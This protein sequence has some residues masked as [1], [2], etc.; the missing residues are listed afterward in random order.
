MRD[1]PDAAYEANAAAQNTGSRIGQIRK[2][3]SAE[4]PV[5]IAAPRRK[6][7]SHRLIIASFYLLLISRILLQTSTF[8]QRFE[9]S[10]VYGFDSPL[11][12]PPLQ[13]AV[14]RPTGT[15]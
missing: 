3:A 9:V 10:G 5:A 12:M 1:A 14:Q 6:I 8:S 7:V 13:S 15:R 11:L 2:C 4:L